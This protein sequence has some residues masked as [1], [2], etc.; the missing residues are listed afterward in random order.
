MTWSRSPKKSN[1]R[2]PCMNVVGLD[3]NSTRARAVHGPAGGK[4]RP[5][6]LD[7]AQSELPLA[8][9]L[10]GRQPE[11]GRAGLALCRRLPHLAVLDF[12][13]YLGDRRDW[14]AGRHRLDAG[15]AL[16]LVL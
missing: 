10:E 9:S 1:H 12:L 14:A 11:V 13:P 8:L 15:R 6:A 3:L 16:A 2:S 7:G 5:I 4:P